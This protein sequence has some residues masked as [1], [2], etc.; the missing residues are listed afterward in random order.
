MYAFIDSVT[1]PSSKLFCKNRLIFGDEKSKSFKDNVI[2][3]IYLVKRH[4]ALSLSLSLS[5]SL[6]G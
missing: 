5:L 6:F 3:K 1:M 4:P 2:A